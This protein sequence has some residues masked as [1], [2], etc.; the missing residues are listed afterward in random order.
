MGEKTK[1]SVWLWKNCQ[2]FQRQGG[3]VDMQ[4][5]LPLTGFGMHF[6]YM[7][8]IIWFWPASLTV[9]CPILHATC[10]EPVWLMTKQN[11]ILFVLSFLSFVVVFS[12][13]LEENSGLL[14]SLFILKYCSRSSNL[15]IANTWK[16]PV[17]CII[18]NLQLESGL[19]LLPSFSL[20]DE[21]LK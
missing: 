21:R 13:S 12:L 2:I 7:H 16:C 10:V 11:P 5:C 6:Y 15:K 18:C 20:K 17:L 19:N 9:S 14:L 3:L 1:R 4:T 8:K